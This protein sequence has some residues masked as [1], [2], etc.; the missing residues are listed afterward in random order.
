MWQ[1]EQNRGLRNHIKA[2]HKVPD[3]DSTI[4][5]LDI[6]TRLDIGPIE[7]WRSSPKIRIM[8]DAIDVCCRIFESRVFE[9][10]QEVGRENAH[11]GKDQTAVVRARV[12][13]DE[14]AASG[15]KQ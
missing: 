3:D 8:K 12:G 10:L 7:E 6:L 5:Q 14:V 9:C 1:L 2:G 4:H 13:R 11:A 15:K